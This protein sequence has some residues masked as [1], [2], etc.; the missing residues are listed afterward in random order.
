MFFQIINWCILSI[1]KNEIL[2]LEVITLITVI[3]NTLNKYESL[4]KALLEAEKTKEPYWLDINMPNEKDFELLEEHFNFHP[5]TIED[6]REKVKRSK[7]HDYVQYHFITVTSSGDFIKGAF[8]Y[9][10]IHIFINEDFIITIHYNENKIIK[11]LLDELKK[12]SNVFSNGTDFIM[13]RILDEIV[14]QYFTLTD[15]LENKIDF[16]EEKAMN[17]PIQQTVTE[18]M[19]TKKT[20]MKLR[21]IVSPIREVLNTLLRHD[22][23]ISEANRIYYSDLYDHILRIYDYIESEQEMITSCLELYSSQLSNSMNKEM[24]F[25]TIITTIMMPLTIITGLY[26]MNFDNMPELHYKYGYF[27]VVFTMVF[28]TISQIIMI[29]FRKRK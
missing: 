10:N 25:L 16:L 21:R 14:D 8:P 22:D 1:Y 5:I 6:C 3:K 19:R 11:R 18:I 7:I 17:N 29:F 20:I 28:I 4:E 9:K 2:I 27:I 24:K 12:E 23:I 13:Y 15:K 26:G